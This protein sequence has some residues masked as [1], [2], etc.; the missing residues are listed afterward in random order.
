MEYKADIKVKEWNL[1][2]WSNEKRNILA[3]LAS[4]V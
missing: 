2:Q 1:P 3:A 4:D